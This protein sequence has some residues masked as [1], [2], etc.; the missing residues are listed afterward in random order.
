MSQILLL[1]LVHLGYWV[2]LKT[3]FQE[4]TARVYKGERIG[5]IGPNGSGKSTLLNTT[6]VN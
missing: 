2:P 4:F 3:C 6:V 5:I 1:E